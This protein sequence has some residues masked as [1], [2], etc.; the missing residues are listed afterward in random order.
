MFSRCSDK[1]K[2]KLTGIV[3]VNK[4][5]PRNSRDNDFIPPTVE[6]IDP[7]IWLSLRSRV[8]KLPKLPICDGRVPDNPLFN[9][10]ISTTLA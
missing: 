5:D 2:H 10:F 1:R 4:L 6:G 3:P 9:K 8:V 7:L